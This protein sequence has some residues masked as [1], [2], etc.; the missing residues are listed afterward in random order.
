MVSKEYND[1]VYQIKSLLKD[2]EIDFDFLEHEE[3][4]SSEGAAKV[5]TGFTLGQGVKALIVFSN[6]V[7]N[8]FFQIIVPGDKKFNDSKLQKNLNISNVRLA[9]S[10]DL[11]R[12]TKGIKPGGIPPFGNLFGLEVYA[13]E[14]IFKNEQ[15]V[16][17][18]GDR[19][20]SISMSSSDYKELVSPT[21]VDITD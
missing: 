16:F 20:A 13:D 17:N 7:E 14:K 10:S 19:G 1:C 3:A 11:D 8:Q 6:D 5:R 4:T 12:I 2:N 9:T 21:I 18:C 15:I